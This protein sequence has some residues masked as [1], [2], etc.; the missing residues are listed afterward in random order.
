MQLVRKSEEDRREK[1]KREAEDRKKERQKASTEDRIHELEELLS[2]LQDEISE[3]GG[4]EPE[5]LAEKAAEMAEYEKEIN[6]LY[7][8]WMK[9]QE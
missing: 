9:L 2:A 7:D 5:W 1:K 3:Q 6:S 4:G 8:E